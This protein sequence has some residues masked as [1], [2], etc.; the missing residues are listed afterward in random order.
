MCQLIS[1]LDY[2]RIGNLELGNGNEKDDARY[3][4][5]DALDGRCE[6]S[7]VKREM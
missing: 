1:G 4:I 7:N 6:M 3:G 2:F 5:R